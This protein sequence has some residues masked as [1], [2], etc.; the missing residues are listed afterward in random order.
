M[1][2]RFI[3]IHYDENEPR[4][5]E[6][7]NQNHVDFL[8]L[9]VSDL[10]DAF[11]DIQPSSNSDC[12]SETIVPTGTL[13]NQPDTRIQFYLHDIVEVVDPNLWDADIFLD[14][15][16]M[17]DA[18]DSIH[19]PSD[20]KAINIYM[21]GSECNYDKRVLLNTNPTCTN[22]DWVSKGLMKGRFPNQN[23]NFSEFLKIYAFDAFSKYKAH[24][25]GYYCH[26]YSQCCPA[27]PISW[28]SGVDAYAHEIGHNLGLGHANQCPESI[29]DQ[30]C[31]SGA[32][33]LYD[34]QLSQMHRSLGIT[35]ARNVV[36]DCPYSPEPILITKDS[37]LNL[38]IRLYQDLII[39]SGNTLTITCKVLM[40][41]DAKI[42]VEPNAKLIIDGGKIT[43][44]C[45]GLWKGIEVWGDNEQHQYTINYINQQGKVH[46]KNG[47]II[48]GAEIGIA[49]YNPNEYNRNTGGIII[50]EDATF[51]NCKNAVFL[52][53]YQNFYPNNPSQLRP[54]L[55]RFDNVEF[56]ANGENYNSGVNYGTG[57]VVLWG[58]NGVRFRGCKFLNLDENTESSNWERSG[59]TSLDANYTVTS[60]CVT[61]P[62]VFNPPFS[63]P[64]Q[65][66]VRSKFENLK[67]GI[68]A[69][70]YSDP[71]KTYTVENS[72]FIGNRTG[73]LNAGV[74]YATIV[75]N[76]FEIT[77]FP[78]ADTL[79]AIAVETGTGFAIEQNDILGSID[80]NNNEQ[81]GIWV[82]NSGIE[83]NRLYNNKI[84]STSY[85][86]LAN[87]NNRSIPD[88]AYAPVDGLLFECN[89]Y[90][91]NFNDIVAVGTSDGDGVKLHQG[92]NILGEEVPAGNKFSDYD[93]HPYR[94]INNPSAWPMIYFYYENESIEIPEFYNTNN[95][96]TEGLGYP[97]DCDANYNPSNNYLSSVLTHIM[98]DQQKDNFN[99][100]FVQYS[101][102]LFSYNQLID[103][104]NTN[105]LLEDIQNAWSS[106]AWELYNGLIAESPY[107]STTA[108]KQAAQT[109]ILPNEMLLDL[110]VANP[111]ATMGYQ[112]IDFLKDSIP[113]SLPV[114]MLDIIVANWS[115]QTPRGIIE[116]Q[117]S[118]LN[119]EKHQSASAVLRHYMNDTTNYEMDSIRT[120]TA[121]KE[122]LPSLY[123]EVMD[124]F[125]YVEDPDYGG[126]MDDIL[127]D[128]DN[129]PDYIHA[130]H[131]DY[132]GLLDFVF[133]NITT[134]GLS[135]LEADT[136]DLE[137]LKYYANKQGWPAV[138]ASGILH[139]T[140]YELFDP[141]P[142]LPGPPQQYR[143]AQNSD[144]FSL[145]DEQFVSLLVYPNPAQV[146]V[147]F[148]YELKKNYPDAKLMIY[149][150][151]GKLQKDFMINRYKG[152]KIWDT[153]QVA[154]GIYMYY[155]QS[156]DKILKNGKVTINN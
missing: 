39:K 120:W 25:N 89:E 64:P 112:F 95:V 74:D 110:C 5:F 96:N 138:I 23:L 148:E 45:N 150:V 152:Q 98:L 48:D 140:G 18:L 118:K 104:G 22:P 139:F 70:K 71:F 47:A 129:L 7:N 12:T 20:N 50:A 154:N 130:L 44:A 31:C 133:Q 51:K 76:N 53:P 60:L 3:I 113:N 69:G 81:V 63:C 15:S 103:G 34:N 84:T 14:H 94:D 38:N 77:T 136:T 46:L 137:S 54:N 122:N 135:I 124:N 26:L 116:L 132:H 6:S 101:S 57:M 72:D 29:M 125:L 109:G 80:I 106:E 145:N 33:F 49:T 52:F 21:T 30:E 100:S 13:N 73:I 55:S 99:T 134:S 24:N 28:Q 17:S 40:P 37:V 83:P 42:I 147:I 61:V 143:R 149:D 155:I 4:N 67:Q 19:P 58:V 87:G 153:R 117:L 108:I 123:A 111:E 10:N 146:M 43:N 128:Y 85:A 92:T 121:K 142:E 90:V 16:S 105:S 41:D 88:V 115:T 56:I 93:N 62:G 102:V 127:I 156:G 107:L 114:Y 32:R 75:L 36:R 8:Q 68:W 141:L 119:E 59:I 11:T 2:L 82:R 1:N 66:I 78:N 35:N 86:T 27:C 65:N 91:D 9:I 151:S 126:L 144:K 131:Y 97:N 79:S